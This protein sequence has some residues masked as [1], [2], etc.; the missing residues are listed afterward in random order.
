[1][2]TV[3]FLVSTVAYGNRLSFVIYFSL[4]VVSL[5]VPSEW[6]GV[7][8]KMGCIDGVAHYHFKYQISISSIFISI[9]PEWC[10]QGQ[11]MVIYK[12]GEKSP[13][14]MPFLA[15]F[16]RYHIYE[17]CASRIHYRNNVSAE[18]DMSFAFILTTTNHM[19]LFLFYSFTRA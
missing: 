6:C 1:M 14:L 16:V 8:L 5:T 2:G 3:P 19:H 4:Y 11:G 17:S 15:N 7:R 18:S 12:S 13:P 9:S 10:G